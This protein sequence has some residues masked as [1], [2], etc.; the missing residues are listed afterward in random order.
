MLGIAACGREKPLRCTG[1]GAWTCLGSAIP[2]VGTCSATAW[3]C[4]RWGGSLW[5]LCSGRPGVASHH[6]PSL[7]SRARAVAAPPPPPPRP[8]PL[9]PLGPKRRRCS[10]ARCQP[11]AAG[12]QQCVQHFGA[13]EP[14]RTCKR[15]GAIAGSWPCPSAFGL[16]ARSRRRAVAVPQRPQLAAA[17]H[18]CHWAA[19]A[20]VS[21]APRSLSKRPV[22]P[23]R[24]CPDAGRSRP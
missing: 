22:G 11:G 24:S 4:P 5:Q 8:K 10:R 19:V 23:L 6:G 20:R 21:S 18:H 3:R 16:S 15:Y 13:N 17:R 14:R 9:R 12:H 7:A 1:G 2:I